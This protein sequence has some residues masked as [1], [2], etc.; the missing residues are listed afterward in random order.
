MAPALAEQLKKFGDA[1][2]QEAISEQQRLET[3]EQEI[4]ND[5]KQAHENVARLE[6]EIDTYEQ[7]QASLEVI[8]DLALKRDRIRDDLKD[9]EDQLGRR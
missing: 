4:R 3:R 9:C 7:R 2:L 8:K 1:D 6:E 5:L